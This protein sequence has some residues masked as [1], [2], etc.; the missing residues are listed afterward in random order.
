MTLF[1]DKYGR[2]GWAFQVF[3]VTVFGL[4]GLSLLKVDLS[5]V[6]QGIEYCFY[7]FGVMC[8]FNVGEHITDIFKKAPNANSTSNA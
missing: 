3:T 8:G 2:K 5:L 4:L 6:K 1:T 7:G